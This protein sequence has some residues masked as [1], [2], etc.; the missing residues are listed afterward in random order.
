MLQRVFA[1]DLLL[2][3]K[4]VNGVISTGRGV[5]S[6][7]RNLMMLTFFIAIWPGFGTLMGLRVM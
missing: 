4:T 7:L 6:S 3:G 1:M 5:L 2:S